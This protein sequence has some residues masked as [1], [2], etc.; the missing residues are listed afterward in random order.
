[1]VEELHLFGISNVRQ[2]DKIIPEDLQDNIIMVQEK[3]NFA[4]II[5]NILLIDDLNKY[6]KSCWRKAWQAI[7]HDSMEL[8]G[9]YNVNIAD[10]KKYVK[11]LTIA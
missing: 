4:G 5:R 9:K 1:M 6:F 3:T 11:D 8:L 2:L 7:E 10:I